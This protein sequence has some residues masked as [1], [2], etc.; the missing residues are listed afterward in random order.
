MRD[1]RKSLG[2][3]QSEVAAAIDSDQAVVSRIERSPDV[4][5]SSL[6]RYASG[7]GARFEA[8]FVL[9]DGRRVVVIDEPAS[10]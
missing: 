10:E 8:A 3:S 7:L 4:L 5:L 6:R 9:A 1:L 2:L